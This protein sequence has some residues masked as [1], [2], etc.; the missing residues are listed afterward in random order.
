MG[1]L[2]V[3][4]F[5]IPFS[6]LATMIAWI[7]FYREPRKIEKF[8]L[9][10]VYGIFIF[11]YSLIPDHE[12]DLNRYWYQ[13]EAIKEMTLNGA[14]E[15]FNDG[16]FIENLVFWIISKMQVPHLLPA[17]STS[18]VYGLSTYIVIDS[19][20]RFGFRNSLFYA[21]LFQSLVFPYLSIVSNVRNICAFSIG[22]ATVY[23]ELIKKKRDVITIA[24]YVSPVF[25][26]KTGLLILLIRLMMILFQKAPLLSVSIVILLPSIIAFFYNNLSLIKLPGMIGIVVRRLIVSSHKYLIGGSDYAERLSRS[27]SANVAKFVAIICI[28]V[29][30]YLLYKFYKNHKEDLLSRFAV[31]SFLMSMIAIAATVF[32]TPAYWRFG[33]GV[34][35]SF[36]P[37]LLYY[38]GVGKNELK[39]KP[40]AF[41]IL[42]LSLAGIRF[43]IEALRSIPRINLGESLNMLMNSNLY[44][45][46]FDVLRNI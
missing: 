34:N 15:Y 37:I 25:M 18:I 39:L 7:G 1:L 27:L 31:F 23:R 44:T 38:L 6:T 41:R 42:M 36:S 8:A 29:Q 33:M 22:I 17:I 45:I 32:D 26:H 3:L 16:L 46:I 2:F 43:T 4:L 9:L 21:I 20:K 24:G 13:I 19:N 11:S 30:A 14:I 40:V 12:L 5:L 10:Y 35:I 28:L